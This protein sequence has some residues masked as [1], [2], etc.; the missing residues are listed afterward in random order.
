MNAISRRGFL[1][2]T[3]AL[4]ISVSANPMVLAADA[5]NNAG[6]VTPCLRF[7]EAGEIFICVP[8]PDMGQGIITTAAQIIAEELEL[9]P[10]SAKIEMMAFTGHSSS[11]G[12]AVE[13][14]LPHGAGGSLSTM[15]MWGELR[16]TAAFARNLFIHAAAARW[17]VPERGLKVS[18]G[19]VVDAKGKRTLPFKD[20]VADTRDLEYSVI[21][22]N[23][24]PKA[25]KAF[26]RIGKDQINVHARAIATG[27]PIFGIDAEIPG[28]LHAVIRRCPHL[29]G[30]L[31]SYDREA[32]LKAPGVRHVVEL[33][34][35]PE[36]VTKTRRVTPGIAI[37]ADSYWQARK[38]ADAAQITWDGRISEADSTDSMKARMLAHLDTGTP[39]DSVSGGDLQAAFEDADQIVEATYWHPHWAHTCMEPHNCIA[40]VKEDSAEI[41]LSHQSLTESMNY[42]AEATGLPVH[43]IKSNIY[44]CGTGLGRK[45]ADDFVMEACLVS[46]EIKAPVKVT[47][48]REDEIE[49]DLVNPSGAY[50]MRASL[51]KKGQITGWHL[52]SAACGWLS[53]A[54]KEPPSGLVDNYLGEWGFIENNVRRGAWRGPQ[55][56]TAGFVTQ[57]FLN[58]LAHAAG[59]DPLDFLIDLYSQ[60]AA[61]KLPTWPYPVLDFSRF[62]AML[63][64][65][66][67]EA[68]YGRKLPAGWGQGIAIYHTF[69]G[70]CAHVV[71]VEMIND[72]KDFRVHRVT[73]AIDCGLAVNP[74]GVRAQVE[75]GVVDGL[76]AARYGKLVFEKG[77]PVSNNFDTY[78]KLR[79][80]EAPMEINTTI[81][82]FGDTEPRGTGEVALPPF[83]PALTNA[84]FAASGKR[85]RE[86]PIM[87]N[88]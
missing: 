4:V 31:V 12:R 5:A 79:L 85:I 53:N 36:D 61:L 46:K 6:N 28:M 7:T 60:K 69:S 50:R 11:D 21:P 33:K 58:E 72:A 34:R 70:T 43:K 29:N 78:R 55:H 54:A 66:A 62:V 84:I 44:R 75:G 30:T 49:Q 35:I 15:T 42:A 9:D 40:D 48:S 27:E 52:R 65:V 25:Q 32:L 68:N 71:E 47:W 38:A 81:M 22:V 45:Y 2:G 24:E 87:E 73:S 13:G 80:A 76:C 16:R 8:V 83:I 82:D 88:L 10:A 26:T 59:R 56:N 1:K 37:V 23:A 74:L 18:G 19:E 39:V 41:W 14:K 51:D 17:Q 63:K 67:K 77:V 3:A 20:L 57:S 64:R 86:L